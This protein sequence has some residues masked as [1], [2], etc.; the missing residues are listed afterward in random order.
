MKYSKKSI[1]MKFKHSDLTLFK[2]KSLKFDT[3]ADTISKKNINK[4]CSKYSSIYDV[5]ICDAY[6]DHDIKFNE[7]I[8]LDTTNMLLFQNNTYYIKYNLI[9]EINKEY[10]RYFE[11]D[12]ICLNGYFNYMSIELY[13]G[14]LNKRNTKLI[15]QIKHLD[16][17][18]KCELW[19]FKN[20]YDGII[21]KN[22][23]YNWNKIEFILNYKLNNIE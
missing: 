16:I 13:Y 14:F 12:I 1:I 20:K 19:D 23:N 22:T 11:G 15:D 3:V 21:T 9:K 8:T 10:C 4:Y 17:I 18:S 2:T 7:N 6:I 5:Y